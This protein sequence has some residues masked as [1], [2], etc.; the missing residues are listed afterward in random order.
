MAKGNNFDLLSDLSADER[1]SLSEGSGF[2]AEIFS[3][4]NSDLLSKLEISSDDKGMFVRYHDIPDSGSKANS[5]YF[6]NTEKASASSFR[7]V[8]NY[9]NGND[10]IDK[11]PNFTFDQSNPD[12]SLSS[13]VSID[14]KG[15]VSLTS[16]DGRNSDLHLYVNINPDGHIGGIFSSDNNIS[17]RIN[18]TDANFSDTSDR[19][20]STVFQNIYKDLEPKI[21]EMIGTDKDGSGHTVENIFVKGD[22]EKITFNIQTDILSTNGDN[23]DSKISHHNTISFEFNGDR[24]T[25]IDKIENGIEYK[26]STDALGSKIESI[27]DFREDKNNFIFSMQDRIDSISDNFIDKD[28]KPYF[29]SFFDDKPHKVDSVNIFEKGAIAH[30]DG[31]IET[32]FD[33]D[34]NISKIVETSNDGK[35][36]T[37][38]ARDTDLS[39]DK[40]TEIYDGV[41]EKINEFCNNE[42]FETG[43]GSPEFRE[44]VIDGKSE[45]ISFTVPIE[46]GIKDGDF[47]TS[48]DISTKVRTET[49][50][51]LRLEFHEDK[52]TKIVET[53]GGVE[54]RFSPDSFSV[55]IK[56][57]QDFSD[58]RDTV[59]TEMRGTIDSIRENFIDGDSKISISSYFDKDGSQLN[60]SPSSVDIDSRG[61]MHLH[62][63]DDNL[64][65]RLDSDG[66]ISRIEERS[67]DGEGHFTVDV[68][69]LNA[70][71]DE[72]GLEV[73]TD[74]VEQYVE[75]CHVMADNFLETNGFDK[76]NVKDI[77]MSGAFT[78]VEIYEYKPD[79]DSTEHVDPSSDIRGDSERTFAFSF[80]GNDLNSIEI[81]NGEFRMG[82]SA[83]DIGFTSMEFFHE[84]RDVLVERA[85]NVVSSFLGDRFSEIEGSATIKT[86]GVSYNFENPIDGSDLKERNSDFFTEKICDDD[87]VKRIDIHFRDSDIRHDT[88]SIVLEN[89]V[90]ERLTREYD[91]QTSHLD[92]EIGTVTES[93]EGRTFRVEILH[94]D[95]PND[96]ADRA[97]VKITEFNQDTNTYERTYTGIIDSASRA[98]MRTDSSVGSYIYQQVMSGNIDNIEGLKCKEITNDGEDRL[99]GLEKILQ[100]YED[101]KNP[102][103]AFADTI[104]HLDNID[105]REYYSNFVLNA[106]GFDRAIAETEERIAEIK[107]EI[108]SIFEDPHGFDADKLNE[109]K[110]ELKDEEDKLKTEKGSNDFNSG[111]SGFKGLDYLNELKANKAELER[112]GAE[113]EREEAKAEPDSEKVSALKE[114]ISSIEART[115]D[116]AIT[117][118]TKTNNLGNE[119]L[120]KAILPHI[121]SPL[122]K[123]I[124]KTIALGGNNVQSLAKI[125]K[126]VDGYNKYHS[127]DS[128]KIET[129]RENPDRIEVAV[130]PE[131]T[132]GNFDFSSF[133]EKMPSIFG[134]IFKGFTE[135][136]PFKIL[137]DLFRP[138]SADKK[139]SDT[140]RHND[141]EKGGQ[142]TNGGTERPQGTGGDT[143]PAL[144]GSGET[145][146][147]IPEKD[148]VLDTDGIE[149]RLDKGLPSPDAHDP[150]AK[151]ENGRPE[152]LD[153]KISEFAS[154]VEK[155]IEI[156]FD[157]DKC[158][159]FMDKLEGLIE[160]LIKPDG[161]HH[162]DHGQNTEI[163]GA[164]PDGETHTDKG[165]GPEVKGAKPDGEHHNDQGQRTE[166]NGV[167]PD[168]EKNPDSNPKVETG[169]PEEASGDKSRLE[170]F[171][172]KF[173]NL[174]NDAFDKDPKGAEIKEKLVGLCEKFIETIDKELFGKTE[175]KEEK[176]DKDKEAKGDTT[177]KNPKS[178]DKDKEPQ[179]PQVE[180]QQEPNGDSDTASKGENGTSG[181]STGTGDPPP[182]TGDD[183]V[184]T[185]VDDDDDDETTKK[186]PSGDEEK[187]TKGAT[188]EDDDTKAK[189]SIDERVSKHRE[190]EGKG[191]ET[192]SN[193]PGGDETGNGG[194]TGV[195]DETPK[196]L[197]E[198]FIDLFDKILDNGSFKDLFQVL[199]GAEVKEIMGDIRDV[200]ME[201]K[202][203]NFEG[204]SDILSF[205]GGGGVVD[206]ESH[207]QSFDGDHVPEA[208]EVGADTS[209][210]AAKSTEAG[211]TTTPEGNDGTKTTELNSKPPDTGKPEVKVEPPKNPDTIKIPDEVPEELGDL[212]GLIEGEP[213]AG[214]GAEL[215]EGAEL[216]GAVEGGAE[217]LGEAAIAAV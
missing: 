131:G 70:V 164:K 133:T 77:Y 166:I 177:E 195:E 13:K 198:K 162:N 81:T 181:T 183:N 151:I 84:N 154:K 180:K 26:F 54:Y 38:I 57:M 97:Y 124:F 67:P 15:R 96:N 211:V 145:G 64:S 210:L 139:G 73:T 208:T 213:G 207:E 86:Y 168:G 214:Q 120:C 107:N 2:F 30:I 58:N 126:L 114:R 36:I 41:K 160:K 3:P 61:N 18:L 45:K 29:Q 44:A 65:I 7:T 24:L 43:N 99:T 188:G 119:L 103:E 35:E 1:T 189:K 109:L 122:G 95:I 14:D 167:K 40:I 72:R 185:T 142:G 66:R 51:D 196:G 203:L 27:S 170:T 88:C 23:A 182:P 150:A 20:V 6:I 197:D 176:G 91:L 194:T 42:K 148:K 165:Q 56:S 175:V 62:G 4:E 100:G 110:H 93:I 141:K 129:D 163:K 17:T 179:L 161:E 112:L 63:I 10:R 47:S 104:R 149:H 31:G 98:D 74:V 49:S 48:T 209:D 9:F 117:F 71:M 21:S 22:F 16:A 105:S 135:F 199:N 152:G 127:P 79:K 206:V 140:E 192:G 128:Q 173:E 136:S 8:D 28:G 87:T 144:R 111:K 76:D 125:I 75:K 159:A 153:S 115:D 12:V 50:Y 19:S 102:F 204:I 200:L 113:L 216:E 89:G 59:L 193:T 108:C 60:I 5:S 172:E 80:N 55:E 90:G 116:S 32:S 157:K 46:Y 85:E 212:E 101:Q 134:D 217:A 187:T 78:K 11:I 138:D 130:K 201:V 174:I 121:E 33:K 106:D 146:T 186:S 37:I 53:I 94:V 169:K 68:W 184:N 83:K 82:Y 92:K 178:T 39:R 25:K 123:E 69:K 205:L 155:I 118:L 215:G 34:G 156:V 158:A 143:D 147:Q 52:L 171:L 190:G 137:G 132:D 191:D 202:S